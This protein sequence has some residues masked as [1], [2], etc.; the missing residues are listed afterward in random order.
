M[1]LYLKNISEK[2]FF[3]ISLGCRNGIVRVVNGSTTHEGRVEYC[4]NG[5]W[6][7]VCDNGWDRL[8]AS[9]VCRQLGFSSAGEF[10][11]SGPEDG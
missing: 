8:D 7:T 6:G 3:L 10:M 4:R 1:L 2:K 5:T 11:L 9:I